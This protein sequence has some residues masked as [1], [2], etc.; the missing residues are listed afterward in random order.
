VRIS[1]KTAET[2]NV[3]NR[4]CCIALKKKKYDNNYNI[5]A[6]QKLSG[7]SLEA[8]SALCGKFVEFIRSKSFV[9]HPSN[10]P[11]G[12]YEPEGL[13]KLQ[14]TRYRTQVGSKRSERVA[15]D[16]RV[17]YSSVASERTEACD[18]NLPSI[19]ELLSSELDSNNVPATR[20][21]PIAIPSRIRDLFTK[22][23]RRSTARIVQRNGACRRPPKLAPTCDSD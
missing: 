17:A 5:T 15:H 2:P 22:N 13:S 1:P 21:G 10:Q 19:G 20:Y 16:G 11:L 7:F 3:R 9:S 12:G 18:N 4:C 8:P 14:T 6:R 23:C